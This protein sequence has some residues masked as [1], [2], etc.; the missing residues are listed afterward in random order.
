MKPIKLSLLNKNIAKINDDCAFGFCF[1]NG[2]TGKIIF[3]RDK[4]NYIDAEKLILILSKMFLPQNE[5]QYQDLKD[6]LINYSVREMSFDGDTIND[7]NENNLFSVLKVNGINVFIQPKT[8]IDIEENIKTQI[9]PWFFPILMSIYTII[10]ICSIAFSFFAFKSSGIDVMFF[11]FSVIFFVSSILLKIFFLKK[12]GY[13]YLVWPFVVDVLTFL[14]VIFFMW[15]FYVDKVFK[16][17]PFSS[18]SFLPPL[19]FSLIY[20]IALI[21]MIIF[22]RKEYKNLK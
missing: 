7:G 14:I 16:F 2:T 9:K 15:L 22:G 8:K 4:I 13:K 12:K 5:K 21:I 3:R 19:L 20:Y 11:V 10:T 17:N 18:A 6:L 1:K